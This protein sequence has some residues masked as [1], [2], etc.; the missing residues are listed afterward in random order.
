[1][2]GASA[3]LILSAPQ[4][5]KTAYA[6]QKPYTRYN[7][8]SSQGKAMLKIYEKAVGD[9]M[10]KIPKGDPRNWDFQ[11]YTHWIPGPINDWNA[12]VKK[13]NDT[14][15]ATLSGQAANRSASQTG[16]GDVGRL[17]GACRQSERSQSIPGIVLPAVASLFHLLLRAD[18]PQRFAERGLLAALLE[19]SRRAVDRARNPAGIPRHRQP[20]LSGQPQYRRQRRQADRCRLRPHAA[21]LQRFQGDRIYQDG[22]Q[23]PGRLLSAA[24][25][26]SARRGACR[27]R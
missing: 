7:A 16:D 11:W 12:A 3:G 23:F 19:L 20:A 4:W 25:R 27:Y 5:L 24:R 10:T 15:Q 18:H 2:T 6:Q 21:Q 17:P 13:K 8:T 1:M 22:Q 26:Q 14:I 9:M